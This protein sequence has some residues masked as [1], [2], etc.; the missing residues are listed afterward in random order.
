MAMGGRYSSAVDVRASGVCLYWI[1]A[2]W[3][4]F[5]N[6][7]TSE[8]DLGMA[9]FEGGYDRQRLEKAAGGREDLVEL[10]ERL[11]RPEPGERLTARAAL[12]WPS[13]NDTRT[14]MTPFE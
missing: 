8:E 10:I 14:R 5:H 3:H 7:L 4:P 11:L 2:G 13:L 6:S 9:V 1:V 12:E